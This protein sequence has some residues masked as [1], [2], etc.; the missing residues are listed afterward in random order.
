MSDYYGQPVIKEPIWK[1]EIAWYL[2]T[3]GLAGASAGLAQLAGDETLE[4]RAWAVALAGVGVS[5]VLLIADL[6]VPARFYNML[7]VVKVTSP[8]SV[9]T[10]ILSASGAAIGASALHAWTGRL[11]RLARVSR[12]AAAALGMPLSTYTAALIAQTAVP[13]WHGARRELPVVFA[14]GAA[15][16]AGAA[17][18]ALTPVASAGPARRLTV[19]GAAAE[20][21]GMAFMEQRLGEVGEP[22]STG[23]A[24]TFKRAAN[25]LIGAGTL[26]VAGWGRRSRTAAV[27]GGALAL[28]GAACERFAIFHAGQ[29]SAADP[30][31]T[32][33]PQR[34][35]VDAGHD[36]GASRK[37]AARA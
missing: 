12:P 5:P 9:G 34:R 10:W 4:R 33:A 37:V 20:V 26:A 14:A 32:V 25:A 2:F 24:G 7:R 8:M 16:S 30:K 18:T 22:Y 3:G 6:G 35:R 13:A 17:A 1:S 19:L 28:A 29:Q 21:A 23:R 27:A 11:P 36:G 15:L 31:Y